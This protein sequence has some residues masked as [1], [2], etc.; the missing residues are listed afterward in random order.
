MAAEGQRKEE[1]H[2]RG[3]RRASGA[4]LAL[5]GPVLVTADREEALKCLGWARGVSRWPAMPAARPVLSC[6][7]ILTPTSEPSLWSS[8]QDKTYQAQ[9]SRV[10]LFVRFCFCYKIK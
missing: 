6:E 4:A 3:H 5:S 2:V 8:T 1:R 9:L 10:F 7:I